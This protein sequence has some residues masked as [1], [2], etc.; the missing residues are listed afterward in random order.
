MKSKLVVIG[1]IVNDTEPLDHPGGVVAYAGIAASYLGAETNVITKCPKGHPYIEFL[2][3]N[4]VR[5]HRLESKSNDITTFQNFYNEKGE[6]KQVVLAKQES[7]GVSD[8]KNFQGD[9]LNGAIILVGTVVG[10]VDM[11]LFPELASFGR[12]AVCPQGYFRKIG[13]AGEVSYQEWVG[14]EKYL[15]SAEVVTLSVEDLTIKGVFQEEFL[16][17]M[18]KCSRIVVLT[19][20]EDGAIIYE[21][22]KEPVRTYAFKLRKEEVKDF[23]GAGD[24]Y[25]SAFLIFYEKTGD[26]RFASVI[27][28]LYA[29]IKITGMNGI[30]MESIPGKLGIA[31]FLESREERLKKFLEDNGVDLDIKD[32]IF[33][34]GTV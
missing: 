29:A 15:S 1:H 25:T 23:T 22:G 26:V 19:K 32:Y 21:Q 13:K 8:L 6:R 10:E 20:G 30:G 11:E 18:R 5:V 12:L 3:S 34:S 7:I 2:E 14:F 4:G 24:T 31:L 28:S 27:A 9:L 33:G 17:R 16:E